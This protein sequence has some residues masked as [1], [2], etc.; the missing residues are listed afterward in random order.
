[1]TEDRLGMTEDRGAVTED[2]L[3]TTEDLW[4]LWT[5]I[6]VFKHVHSAKLYT[7]FDRYSVLSMFCDR[8]FS[9]DAL[10]L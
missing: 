3:G 5:K 8:C 9:I 2:R 10:I 4:C 6:N 7:F 1:M